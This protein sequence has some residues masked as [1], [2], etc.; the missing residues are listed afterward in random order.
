M[1]V[2]FPLPFAAALSTLALS[3]CQTMPGDTA[4]ATGTPATPSALAPGRLDS[5]EFGAQGLVSAADPRAA[6]AGAQ[7]LRQGGSAT[8]AALATMLA[9][10]V[11]E[12]QSSG[13]GGGGFLVMADAAGTVDTVDGREKAPA[14][15]TPQWFFR[16]GRA[17]A[18]GEARPGGRSVGV[19]GSLRLAA[20]AHARHGKLAWHMLF[21]PA[22]RLARDGFAVTPRLHRALTD[23]A[24]IAGLD[25]AGR[26]LFYGADGQPLPVGTI[27]RNPALATTLEA[28]A[29]R[30]A[31][32][33]YSGD[34]AAEI[35][36][37]VGT[38]PVNPAPM[39]T[40]DLA[41]FA[42]VGRPS[43][44]GTYRQ[45]RICSMGPPSSGATTVLATLGQLER[46][47]MTALGPQSPRAW[48]LLAES[49]R[50]AYAD[51]DKY[52][53]D[54]DFVKVPT[55]GL[56]D[57]AYL[58]Q[59]SQ[60]IAQGS[61]LP[62]A[63]AGTPAGVVARLAPARP[64]P[65]FGTS[66]FVAVDR[67]GN[68]TSYTSTVESAF[69]SGLMAG[70]YFL[71]NELTDFNLDPLSDGQPT[72]NRVEGGK[73]PRSSMSP[74]VVYGPDGQIRLVVGAAGGATI[75]A[76]VIRVIIG[77]IDWHL[78]AQQ[79][80]ALPVLFAPG[81]RVCVEPG[82]TLEAMIP[83]LVALGHT[84]VQACPMPLKANAVERVGKRWM[85]AADPRSE[86]AAIAQ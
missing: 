61:S 58:A 9:L 78:T 65:E 53:A 17:M 29:R 11:V 41:A 12:P 68:A 72:A 71:N 74:T 38:A 30:G 81:D 5:A 37:K 15:A 69:G 67:W 25:P 10:T 39:T 44:C 54:P 80:I 19:P 82:T 48:H 33:F 51:R 7:M 46:F 28:L 63:M 18:F 16:D 32:W 49:E 2:R 75:P 59:R 3:A 27:V 26:A 4:P 62:H 60:L 57:P 73:R 13:I 42:A 76:Q 1:I 52:L 40:A 31:D 79:A 50:L 86:G 23:S 36:R 43:V 47:D 83:A 45:Y 24:A 84:Q 22:I 64:Q 6:D 8:D 35:A 66:H 85:G 21:Q 14:A 77:V 56:V 34:N 70:G 55:A 20:M